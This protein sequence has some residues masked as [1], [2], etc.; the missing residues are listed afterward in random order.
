MIVAQMQRDRLRQRLLAV[1]PVAASEAAAEA[2]AEVLLWDG[3]NN[4]FSFFQPDWL[5]VVADPLR[6]G[7]E[8]T[9]HPGETNLR[10]A[11]TVLIN[12]VDSV[13]MQDVALLQ[14]SIA[15]VNSKARVVLAASP[16]R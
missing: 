11:D 2:E 5:V 10:M 13:S 14:A 3:G 7:H 15:E 6:L 9:Y 12:K 16:P 8:R 4:D 1:D